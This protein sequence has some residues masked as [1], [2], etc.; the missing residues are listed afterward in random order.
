MAGK[1]NGRFHAAIREGNRFSLLRDGS[2]FFPRMIAAIDESRE[3]V[4]A[5]FYLVESG[6]VADAFIA[7][8]ARAAERGVQ[9][10]VLFDAF[11]ARGLREADRARLRSSGTKLLFYNTPRWRT[12]PR[13]FLRNHRKLLVVDNTLGF[14]GGIGIADMFSAAARPQD[15]WMDCVVE[16]AGPVLDDWYRLFANTWK[17]SARRELDV[18]LRPAP[19]QD[20]GE[21]GCVAA[22]SGLGGNEVGYS[23]A[24][25]IRKARS[26]VWVAT[27]Y[28]WPSNR[29]RRALRRAA[30]RGVD[31]RLLLPGPYT[32]AP[33][34]RAAA[35]LFYARLLSSGVVI[36]EYQP[37][38]L[39]T[40]L[41]VCDDWV[42]IG[43]S[44]LDR[45]GVIWNLEAN[46]EIESAT[47]AGNVQSMLIDASERSI[48]LRAADEV[49]HTWIVPVWR[50]VA[51]AILAW[52]M[53]AV[54]RLRR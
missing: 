8:F 48:S 22:S 34:A 36:Y 47:F 6:Q 3:Y 12:F 35:R 21:R 5:E 50:I 45:W 38:F 54:S 10:R 11:G 9:V 27:A 44:N 42:S 13:P 23:V 4:L 33:A 46:Q 49:R 32:D 29:L 31:V 53:R 43:S 7:A 20:L 14:T 25:R 52:S 2:E 19:A 51:R 1:M 16:I 41:V 17:R 40:K 26:R 30:R 15:Y 28:F 24:K 18:Q 39:H 37:R